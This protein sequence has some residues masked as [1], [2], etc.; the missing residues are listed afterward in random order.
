MEGLQCVECAERLRDALQ[1]ALCDRDQV[2]ELAVTAV[3]AQIGVR[4]L[5]H[6]GIT[7]APEGGAQHGQRRLEVG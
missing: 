6:L 4:D 2:E 5:Q 3:F 1:H 7:A